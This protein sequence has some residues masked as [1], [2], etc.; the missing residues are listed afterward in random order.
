[1][2]DSLGVFQ[3]QRFARSFVRSEP[4]G[5]DARIETEDEKGF[6]TVVGQI[7][8]YVSIDTDKDRHHGKNSGNAD[9]YAQNGEKRAHLVLTQ[10]G[11]RHLS[12]LADVH[13]HGNMHGPHTS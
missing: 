13:A 11:K 1:M 8:V 9:D 3:G 2:P 12:V 5:V 7:G 6:G 10:G 4:A